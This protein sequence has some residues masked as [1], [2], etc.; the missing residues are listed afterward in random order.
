MNEQPKLSVRCHPGN[1]NHH[2]W[3]NHGTFW[4]HLT[5]HFPDFTKHR[6]RLSLGTDNIQHARR[7]R[8]ALLALLGYVPIAK[9]AG[10]EEPASAR[11]PAQ[12]AHLSSRLLAPGFQAPSLSLQEAA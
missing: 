5:V 8:D 7:L 10:G 11:A 1:Q 2:L 4:C 12:A 6:L 9:A 3:N